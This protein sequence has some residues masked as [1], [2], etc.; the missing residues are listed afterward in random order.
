MLKRVIGEGIDGGVIF[1]QLENSIIK[2]LIDAK[3][4]SF[5]T[6]Y[7][8]DNL[9]SMTSRAPNQTITTIHRHYP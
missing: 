7:V 5:Y 1:L 4:L 9:S 8:D 3:I 6:R 2:H